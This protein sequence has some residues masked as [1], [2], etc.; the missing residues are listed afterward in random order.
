MPLYGR[1]AELRGATM[2]GLRGAGM[3]VGHARKLLA[4]I[5]KLPEPKAA[6]PEEEARE[7]LRTAVHEHQPPPVLPPPEPPPPN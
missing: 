3:K 6:V 4:T 7:L 5:E 1:C 2:A